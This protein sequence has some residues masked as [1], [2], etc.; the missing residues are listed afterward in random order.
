MTFTAA[1]L[2]GLGEEME[3]DPMTFV[4]G[5]GAGVRGGN[6]G[7]TVGLFDKY[8]PARLR[9]T[10]IT[11]RGFTGL[12]TGAAMTGARPIVDYM[13]IDFALDGLGYLAYRSIS[14][15]D[16]PVTQAIVTLLSFIYVGLTLAGDIIN[17]WIDPRIRVG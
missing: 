4:V 6:F 12:C 17:A 9:D 7:T 3:R 11:E 14:N 8:G 13:F 15:L 16:L 5:E 10:P 1:A 2:E